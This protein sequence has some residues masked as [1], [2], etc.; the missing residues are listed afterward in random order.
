ML[1]DYCRIFSYYLM[2]LSFVFFFSGLYMFWIGL[3]LYLDWSIMIIN[4]SEF[5]MSFVFDWM[6]LFFSFFV[7]FISSCVMYYSVD[8]MSG[9]WNKNRFGLLV[10]MFVFSMLLL[11]NSYSI[12]S[13]LLGWDG[14]GL[15]SYCLVIYYQNVRS[16]N[17][18]MITILSNR[19]G[20]S[21]I[22]LVISWLLINGD[23]FYMFFFD[24][25]GSFW[26]IFL[27]LM[28]AF[29]KSAQMPFS[30]WLPAAMAAPTP[31]SALVHSSTL[32][33]AGVY[34][35]IRYGMFDQYYMCYDFLCFFSLFT[36]FMSGLG[37]NFEFDLSSI[38]AL[39]TLSQLGIMMFILSIGYYELAYFHLLTHAM[40][41]A[42]LFLCAGSY[43]HVVGDIQDIRYMGGMVYYSPMVSS[44][45][46]VSNFA[47]FGFPFLAGFYS[48]DI[49]IEM[50]LVG[51][52]N[53]FILFI[54]GFSIGLTSCY[55][56]RL[57][58]YVMWGYV[59]WKVSV[60]LS[61]CG[62]I[63]MYPMMM[64]GLMAIFSGSMMMWIMFPYSFYVFFGVFV[65]LLILTIVFGGVFL[66]MVI[67]WWMLFYSNV[68]LDFVSSM[69]FLTGLSGQWSTKLLVWYGGSMI[70]CVDM[71][72]F[73]YFGG[74]GIYYSFMNI[75]L[76]NQWWQN[77]SFSVYMFIFLMWITFFVMY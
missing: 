76:L 6:S 34:L 29:T 55:C 20:D 23:W 22:L 75:S 18:G 49:I 63:M 7:M 16:Y 32:V 27:S 41:S 50:Y 40:F 33:T 17:A 36:M 57:C 38:I 21:S 54:F 4:S 65:S 30:A 42:L 1:K 58:Y 12:V 35:L 43:I 8:Y 52:V 70:H 77:N 3:G 51:N 64:L 74:N 67:S 39:S 62:N 46:L 11:I 47:L 13:L 37:A 44:M 5:T 26:V 56:L 71:G 59:N 60:M 24:C 66:G 48:K 28:A 10:F 73:E 25:E 15:V 14:L 45:F 2:I 68:F 31:V 72:W 53:I 61:D 19:I 9:D 69:W